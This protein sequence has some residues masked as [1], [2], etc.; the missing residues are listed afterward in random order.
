MADDATPDDL[1]QRLAE[2]SPH[3]PD[4]EIDAV[5]VAMCNLVHF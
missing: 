1:W 3:T 2:E 5:G 4:E